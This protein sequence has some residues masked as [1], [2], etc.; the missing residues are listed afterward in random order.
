MTLAADQTV[1]V[2]RWLGVVPLALSSQRMQAVVPD[3]Q[4]VD[5]E[6]IKTRALTCGAAVTVNAE[7]GTTQ[8][9]NFHGTGSTAYVKCDAIEA[10]DV[11]VSVTPTVTIDTVEYPEVAVKAII[12]S[13]L[14][15]DAVGRIATAVKKFFDKASPAGT[16]NSLPDAVAGA[17]G[18]IA[19]VG[20]A[21]TLAS[22]SIVTATFGTCVT[23]ETTKTALLPA[24]AAGGKSGL[25][26]TDAA[27]GLVLTGFGGGA[28]NVT[29]AASQHVIVDSGTVTILTNLPTAPTNWLT[30]AAVKDDAVTKIQAG[31]GTSTLTTGDIDARLAAYPVQKSGLAVTLP[32]APEGYG[33]D[34]TDEQITDIAEAVA[35]AITTGGGLID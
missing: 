30:G 27:T 20:S 31:L 32:S 3:T 9:V 16:I 34:L 28:M 21:M 5:V 14:T 23:P 26:I 11:I 25:P 15:E 17:S 2:G 33:G 35:A 4:K 1:D 12:A 13:L 18:G 22:G 10:A 8:P 6:T 7:I 19:I 29:L 24:V